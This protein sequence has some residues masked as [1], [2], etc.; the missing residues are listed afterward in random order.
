MFTAL[1]LTQKDKQTIAKIRVYPGTDGSFSLYDDDGHTYGYERGEMKLT[2]LHWEDA[3][4]RFT[5]DGAKAWEASPPFTCG[6][7]REATR[8]VWGR[9]NP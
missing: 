4:A 6:K 8:F 9:E 2:Q 7:L 5:H 3:A 1:L